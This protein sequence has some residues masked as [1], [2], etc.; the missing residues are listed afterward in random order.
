MKKF[1]SIL[2]TAVIL[3]GC[4]GCQK[5]QPAGT[6]VDF[7][8]RAKEPTYG[9]G[10]GIFSIEVREIAYEPTD[11]QKL[12]EE[13]LRGARIDTCIS[14]FPPGTALVKLSLSVSGI[15]VELSP[16]MA[17]QSNAD[18]IVCCACLSKTLF[19]I[20]DIKTVTF[21]IENRDINGQSSITFDQESFVNWDIHF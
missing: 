8:Y 7:Y 10:D 13:Y 5:Q 19:N 21:S 11:Y 16:H 17:F 18:V 2:L 12:I 4:C 20:S 1:L 15:S 9:S 6:T 3:L 14:P